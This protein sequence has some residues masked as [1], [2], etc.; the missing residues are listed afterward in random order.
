MRR[1]TTIVLSVICVAL[2]GVATN[3]ATGALPEQWA[4]YL[5][6]AWPMLG[7][8]IVTLILVEVVGGRERRP[9]PRASPAR[10]RQVLLDRVRRY[11][12]TN[13]LERSL[14]NE[15][16]IELGFTAT[17]DAQ[18]HP[19][20]MQAAQADGT[21]LT[22]TDGVSMSSVFTRLDHG[23]VILGEPGAGKTTMLLELARDLLNQADHDSSASI[24]VVVNLSSWAIHRRPIDQWLAEQLTERYGMPADQATRWI[25]EGEIL[26]LLDGLDEVAGEYRN[27]CAVAITE[28]HR[29][30]PLTP[31]AICCRTTEYSQ[32][33]QQV[34]VY[35]TVRI[36]PLTRPQ[37]EQFLDRAGTALAGLRATLAV[38][39]ELWK[40]ADSPL[41]LSIMAL[42]Y[43][44][45]PEPV[46]GTTGDA[47]SPDPTHGRTRLFTQYV[48]AMLRRRRDRR[49]RPEQTVR[50]LAAVAYQLSR[51]SQTVFV[52]DQ[53]KEAWSLRYGTAPSADTISRTVNSLATGLFFG[54][55]GWVL[56]GWPGALTG[57]VA[58]GVAMTATFS[59]AYDNLSY[60]SYTAER[61][62][63][64]RAERSENTYRT[65]WILDAWDEFP[66]IF[67]EAVPAV[68]MISGA[69]AVGTAFGIATGVDS[70][71]GAGILAGVTYGLGFL[72][73][74]VVG[75][76]VTAAAT[77]KVN[78]WSHPTVAVRREVPSPALRNRLRLAVRVAPILGLI[79][80]TVSGLAVVLP[81]TADE[82]VRFGALVGAGYT[83][84]LLVQVALAPTVEQWIVRRRLARQDV[85]PKR[86][87]PFLEYAVQCLFLRSVGD[88]YI[89]VHR[90]LLDF[91]AERWKPWRY[92]QDPLDSAGFDL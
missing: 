15:A 50:Y 33:N 91:F 87:V 38:D 51:F 57:V 90:E 89:F 36:Q 40:F 63:N 53:I 54:T 61:R 60:I 74:T 64:E 70:G 72:L 49:I 21:P 8:L 71:T 1:V 86:M 31:I 85:V 14:Y 28:F 24:P 39:A 10:A 11:W 59:L 41:L 48:Q 12:V 29:Q 7:V 42:A 58:G 16:R 22:L 47:D 66:E 68:G 80:G 27:Q 37:I 26:P 56:L 69:L 20:D 32:L 65:N 88:G 82:A 9:G 23:M 5:W 6:L 81:A 35:G 67:A 34:P 30:Q 75:S 4:P 78:H 83:V 84:F 52:L 19:W 55:A 25:A 62:N 77:F 92:G 3:V 13:V 18:R 2:L 43:A 45:G 46:V 17:A 79:T 73:A 44:D 76:T